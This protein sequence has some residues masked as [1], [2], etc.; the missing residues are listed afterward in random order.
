ML[1]QPVACQVFF[2]SHANILMLLNKVSATVTV[3]RENR[4]TLF[5]LPGII[6]LFI[7]CAGI[8]RNNSLVDGRQYGKVRGIKNPK[9]LNLVPQ[10]SVQVI[11]SMI[12]KFKVTI[13]VSA[14]QQMGVILLWCGF[15]F[16]PFS[17]ANFCFRPTSKLQNQFM[18]IDAQNVDPRHS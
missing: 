16:S 12:S 5:F 6:S 10:N 1:L 4:R 8:I 3:Y 15:W 9:P 17:L 18:L 7:M 13:T 14:S 11:T 2:F